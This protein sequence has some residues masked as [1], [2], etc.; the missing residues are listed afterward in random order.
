MVIFY[1]FSF[2]RMTLKSF[3]LMRKVAEELRP[4]QHEDHDKIAGEFMKAVRSGKA[5]MAN[6]II[7]EAVCYYLHNPSTLLGGLE[8]YCEKFGI[9]VDFATMAEYEMVHF[10]AGHRNEISQ[11]LKSHN[12]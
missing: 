8:K 11:R 6:D 4:P 10:I 12:L 2:K 1:P 5:D 3:S 7:D 9:Q